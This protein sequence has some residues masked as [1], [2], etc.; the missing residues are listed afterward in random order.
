MEIPPTMSQPLTSST[1][2]EMPLKSSD[3][4]ASVPLMDG[5]KGKTKKCST[6]KSPKKK[7]GALMDDVKN[8]AVPFAILLAKQGLQTMFDK[9]ASKVEKKADS[10]E[11]SVSARRKTAAGGSCGTQ[12]AVAAQSMTGGDVQNAKNANAKNTN[13]NAKNANANAK[14]ANTNAKNANSNTKNA[15]TNAKNATRMGG[16]DNRSNNVK[17][18]FEKLSKE[19]DEFLAKY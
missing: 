5:G 6:K 1:M 11:L 15:N 10:A 4:S 12:C 14:N 13:T 17:N 16:S 9:K 8:L 3:S 18:R 19:I 2:M 7:G